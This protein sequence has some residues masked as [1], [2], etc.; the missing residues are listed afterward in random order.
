VEFP[1]IWQVKNT[2][3][4]DWTAE[5]RLTFVDGDRMGAPRSVKL[6]G[7]IR[8]GESVNLEVEFVAPDR[9]GVYSGEWMLSDPDGDEFGV[10]S[11]GRTPLLVEIRDVLPP[12]LGFAYD[13]AANYCQATWESDRGRIYCP[14]ATNRQF[15]SVSFTDE[16]TLEN[17]RTENEETL[18]TLPQDKN[19][20][21]IEGVFPSYKVKTGDHFIADVGCLKDSQG[22]DVTFYV[23]YIQSDGQV[24]R[25]GSWDEDYDRHPHRPGSILLERANR[26]LC[27]GRKGQFKGEQSQRLLAGALHSQ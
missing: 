15:G 9:K 10:G 7:K 13:F 21:Y 22:C 2:G 23:D 3:R 11:N 27:F 8:A 26:A 6:P 17:N 12:D 19:K 14:T 24:K 5:Y 1:K 4:C 20:G 25:L 16:P 18:L